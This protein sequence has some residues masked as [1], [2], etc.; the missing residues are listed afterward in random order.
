MWICSWNW[1]FSP[2]G[3]CAAGT[4]EDWIT[5]MKAHTVCGEVVPLIY[6]LS[7][8]AANYP[9]ARDIWYFC[10]EMLTIDILFLL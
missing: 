8:K 4:Q 7:H 10:T 6:P 2:G 9:T 5:P 1:S 3:L